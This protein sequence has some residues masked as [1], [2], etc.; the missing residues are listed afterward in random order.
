MYV[1][2]FRLVWPQ[3]Q[4]ILAQRVAD[5]LQQRREQRLQQRT[6]KESTET[7]LVEQALAALEPLVQ[8]Q[9]P[10]EPIECPPVQPGFSPANAVWYTVSGVVLGSAISLILVSVFRREE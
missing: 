8:P 5:Y 9:E 7:L 6:G 10:G 2:I 3:L 1:T 4:R